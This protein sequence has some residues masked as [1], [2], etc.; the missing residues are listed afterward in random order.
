MSTIV[1]K[2]GKVIITKTIFKTARRTYKIQYIER[3]Q[4][5]RP[6]FLFSLPLSL[7]AMCLLSE[8][9]PYLYQYEKYACIFVATALPVFFYNLGV[10]S[11]ASKALTNDTAII[12]TVSQLSRVRHALESVM[13]DDKEEQNSDD[14]DS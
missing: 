8:Y 5:K 7:G 14:I 4:I 12:G 11:L 3:L 1:Y 13:Y 6:W 2:K 10:L 9:A